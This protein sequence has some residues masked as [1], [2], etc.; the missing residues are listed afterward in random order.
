MTHAL[1]FANG[2]VLDGPV[3]RHTLAAV[4]SPLIVAADGGARV[5]QHFGL[6][7]DVV[8][9]DMDSLSDGELDALE[10]AGAEIVRHP[11]EKDATD[12][13]LALTYLVER[14]YCWLRI[15]GGLG[16]RLDQ[17]IANVH[18][19]MLPQLS[20]CDVRLVAGR[21]E[22][23]LLHPGAYT[24]DGT[25]GDTVSLIPLSGAVHG[26]RT[27]GLQYPLEDET[28]DF[29]P[30]RGVSNVMESVPVHISFGEGLLLYIRTEG[31]A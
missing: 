4:E 5:A 27:G 20:E 8:I 16:D 26:I 25:P 15:I 30:A 9:G 19:L 31:R 2:D 24:L 6:H 14:G 3:V 12:L 21:Q 7:V 17:T 29:G 22:A 1:V 18:L 28:L 11:P 13:E 10:Q 23:R